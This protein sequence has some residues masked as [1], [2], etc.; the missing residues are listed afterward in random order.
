MLPAEHFQVGIKCGQGF[1]AESAL[2][3]A[4]AKLGVLDEE[5]EALKAGILLALESGP[6]DAAGLKEPLGSLYKHY[7]EA[8]KK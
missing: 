7:G 2:R 5:V 1:N 8:G 6:L 3:A 4:R